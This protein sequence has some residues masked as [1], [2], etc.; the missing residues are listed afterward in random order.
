MV[1]ENLL[2]E[3]LF[4]A[5][6]GVRTL[7][8]K[9]KMYRVIESGNPSCWQGPI[10]GISNYIC[11]RGLLKYGFR[12]EAKELAKKRFC[13]L[14]GVFWRTEIFTSTTIRKLAMA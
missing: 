1:Q 2:R 5:P 14:V 10:W 4:W 9:E 13:C 7:S 6:Y 8:K 11:F 3:D 12:T